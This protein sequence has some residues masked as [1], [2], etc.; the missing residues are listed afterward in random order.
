[1]S[2]RVSYDIISKTGFGYVVRVYG[3]SLA[4]KMPVLVGLNSQSH[5]AVFRS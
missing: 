2:R 3:R 4:R 1:M 5:S